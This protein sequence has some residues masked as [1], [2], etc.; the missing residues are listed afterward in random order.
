MKKNGLDIN[1]TY[2]N[3][4]SCANIIGVISESIRE[5]VSEKISNAEYLSILIDGDTDVSVKEC[6]IIYARIIWEGKPQNILVGHME[7]EN[8]TADGMTS[9]IVIIIVFY[10]LLNCF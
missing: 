6:E 5:D 8:A 9:F 7:V 4:K 1:M 3:D 2:A 10:K